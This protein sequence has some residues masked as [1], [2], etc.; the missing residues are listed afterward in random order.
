[1]KRISEK[2]LRNWTL[3]V[4]ICCGFLFHDFIYSLYPV[5]PLLLALMMFF[6]CSRTSISQMRVRPIHIMLL[7]VQVFG[8]AG[9][10]FLLR[11]INEPLAQ[12]LM[13][14]V[15]TPVAT[16]S[17]VVGALLGAD[18]TLMT[19]YVLLSNI[20]AAILAPLFFT[21]INPGSDISFWFSFL[22]IIKKTVLLLVVPLIITWL[23]GKLTPKAHEYVRGC[24]YTSFYL[25]ALCMMILIGSTIHSIMADDN[26]DVTLEIIMAA[27]SLIL[28]VTLFWIGRKAGIRYGDMVAV[29]QMMGQKNTGIGIWMTI[30]FLMPLASVVPAAYIVWQNLINSMEIARSRK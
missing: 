30:S 5:T 10:Y 27:S 29:R 14:C 2:K 11:G 9:I 20:T 6:T 12:G 19:T 21:Y 25:W 28:C 18:V 22:H 26:P 13:I 4:A 1:M 24:K 7:C 3:P 16:A 17:P 15:F 8:G 23:M